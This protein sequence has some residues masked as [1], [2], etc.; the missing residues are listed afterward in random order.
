[1]NILLFDMDGVLLRSLGYHIA[2]QHMVKKVGHALG[3]QDAALTDEHIAG[4]ESHGMTC[5]W[6]SG[7]LTIAY[8]FMKAKM[9]QPT[10]RF[11]IALQ[12]APVSMFQDGLDISPL[13]DTLALFP[14][15]QQPQ[16]QRA[17]AVIAAVAAQ[18]GLPPD[19]YA[20]MVA[21]CENPSL[22]LT[23]RTFQEMV[24]GSENYQRTYHLPPV[25]DCPSYLNL[26]DQVLISDINRERL[27]RWQG[28]SGQYAAI[29]TNRPSS[30]IPGTPS[31][32]EAE[33]GAKLVGLE[34]L[35]LLAFGEIMWLSQQ[36]GEESSGINKP[37]PIHTLAAMQAALG[38]S[39]PESMMSAYRLLN[40]PH[41]VEEWEQLT[42]GEIYIFE[43]TIAGV[44]SLEK[45]RTAL[46][47][48]GIKINIHKIGITENR[49][50]KAA[51]KKHGAEV[52]QDINQALGEILIV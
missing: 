4:F 31:T 9:Q 43:D 14:S 49:T 2:L 21:E 26:Y 16:L 32:P 34:K 28:T 10:L 35:P 51:L 37:S 17:V 41:D 15:D 19:E 7:A 18:A 50:K 20:V 5:E 8:L 6:H 12:P 36:M 38:A 48:V 29:V 44:I 3:Y 13:L 46:A 25:L 27:L 24:L 40:E 47:E 39:L 52:F 1:M 45:A 23:F 33:L 22:S 11:P 30:Q 42:N